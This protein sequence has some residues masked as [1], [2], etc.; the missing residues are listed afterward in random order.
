MGRAVQYP[1]T[2]H[3]P[4]W[5]PLFSLTVVLTSLAGVWLGEKPRVGEGSAVTGAIVL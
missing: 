1:P 2:C 5:R 3:D 4:A